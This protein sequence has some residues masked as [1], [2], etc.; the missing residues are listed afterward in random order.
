MKIKNY[1][2]PVLILAFLTTTGCGGKPS[3]RPVGGKTAGTAIPA[4]T[5]ENANSTSGSEA[6]KSGG[7]TDLVADIEKSCSACHSAGGLAGQTKRLKNHPVI[8]KRATYR[9]CH[10]CHSK[11]PQT[12]AK[13]VAKLQE[14]HLHNQVFLKKFKEP[15]LGC[16]EIK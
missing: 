15:C 2:I 7:K 14:I 13:S 1:L 5:T 10:N 6:V 4:E 11:E 16:H 12:K 3:G 8:N 9:D